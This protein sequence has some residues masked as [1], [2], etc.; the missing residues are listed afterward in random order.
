MEKRDFNRSIF[1]V[2]IS[3]FRAHRKL[4]I[5]D[6]SCAFAVAAVDVAFPLVSRYAMYELLPEKLFIAFFTVMAIAAAAFALE[7]Y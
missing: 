7:L 5:L 2:F 1:K 3:Y 6:M 4:F